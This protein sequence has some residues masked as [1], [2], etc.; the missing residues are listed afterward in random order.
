MSDTNESPAEIEVSVVIPC[1]NVADT[2]ESCIHKAQQGLKNGGI[3]GEIIV[4][5]NGSTDASPEIARKEGVLALESKLEDLDDEFMKTGLQQIVDGVD[6]D[7][8]RD[9]LEIEL[10]SLD[11]RQRPKLLLR[12]LAKSTRSS[13][14][15]QWCSMCKLPTCSICCEASI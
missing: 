7:A 12:D 4:A 5:D 14:L 9:T 2:L 11:E 8:V 15:S 1:L 10:M 13:I 3:R 6:A